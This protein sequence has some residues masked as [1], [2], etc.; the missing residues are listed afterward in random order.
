MPFNWEE[1]LPPASLGKG[2]AMGLLIEAG[3]EVLFAL[4]PWL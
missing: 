3:F 4:F 1:A 2:I